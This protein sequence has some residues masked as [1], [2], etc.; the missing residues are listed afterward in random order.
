MKKKLPDKQCFHISVKDRTTGDNAEKFDGRI[1]DKDY[2]A[3]KKIWNEF[4]MKNIGDYH[5]H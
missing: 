4:N 2:L 3:C 1:S 5:D